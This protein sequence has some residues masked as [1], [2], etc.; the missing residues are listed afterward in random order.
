[1]YGFA[2]EG[3]G[4]LLTSAKGKDKARERK[5]QELLFT[6]MDPHRKDELSVEIGGGKHS[7]STDSRVCCA[8]TGEQ[9]EM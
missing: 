1:M 7:S 5:R 9:V 4:Y 2:L 8:R 6:R 3:L